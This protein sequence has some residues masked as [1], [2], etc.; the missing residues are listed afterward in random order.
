MSKARKDIARS[1]GTDIVY[2]DPMEGSDGAIFLARELVAK[3]PDAY[4]YPDQY[5]NPS[6]WRAHY[7]GTGR[8]IL[9]DL[10]QLTHFVA[11]LGTTGTMMG[12]ARRI[13]DSGRP[14]ECIA[15]E[16]AEALHGL[17]GLK[18]M[19]TSLVPPIYDP[20]VP[21]RILPHR[22]T[23]VGWDTA[24]RLA[25]EEGLARR[26]LVGGQHRRGDPPRR[27][28]AAKREGGLR[29][30]HR[31]RPWRSVLRAHEVGTPVRVVSSE[32]LPA[33]VNSMRDEKK[34]PWVT[35]NLVVS[36]AIVDRVDEEARKA[37]GRDEESC[38][39][40]VGPAG[41]ARYVDGVVP[42]IN[43]A[44]ALHRLDPETYPRTGRTYF[45]IDSMKFE[46]AI[47][48][49][50]SE[51]R[52][53]KVL[54]HSHLD[55]GAYFSA[56]DAEVAKMGQGE[57]PWDLAYLVTSVLKGRVDARTLFVWSPEAKEFVESPLVVR[58][59]DEGD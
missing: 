7:D 43:R 2:S 21:D 47:A 42:M 53:V 50:E 41:E 44:N 19:A 40:L 58:E 26:A 30:R 31:V 57:P 6:N 37:Y 12:C 28:G 16:P 52:P 11:G 35:G 18:H 51:A 29:R 23:E 56:T 49:S 36:R 14:V 54:Y 22:Q 8:E 17:E 13:K 32:A 15:V 48:R 5:S 38:G 59:G 1:F 4:F 10:P 33:A 9:E 24:D 34:H 39:F 45:D 20:R 55:A 25:R 27:R 46:S 3:D